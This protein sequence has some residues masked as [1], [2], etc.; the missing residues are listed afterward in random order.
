[1]KRMLAGKVAIVT[2]GASGIGRALSEE[3]ATRG[4]EV[5]IADRQIDAACEVEAKIRSRGERA[6]AVE[7]DV[8]DLGAFERVVRDTLSHSRRIDFLFNSAGIGVGGEMESYEPEDFD[9]V[10]DVNLRGVAWGIQTVYPI[11]I[12]QRSGHIVNTASVAGLVATPGNGSYTATKHAIVGLSKALRIEAARHGVNVS[13]L[14]PGAVRTS[15]SNGRRFARVRMVGATEREIAKLW[16]RSRPMAPDVFARRA[17][18][19]VLA[20]DPL[21]VL[22]G[23]WKAFWYLD[24]ISPAMSMAVWRRLHHTGREDLAMEGAMLGSR[25]QDMFDHRGSSAQIQVN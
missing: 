22:P 12:R 8:R 7:L 9:D 15:T 1:M 2:G 23:W 3:L 24:R 4:C 14:C 21:I 17:V 13:V 19:R 11:M 20:N 5:I 18:S 25:G 16:E 6:M 10:I